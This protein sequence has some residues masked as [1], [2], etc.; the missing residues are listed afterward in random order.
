MTTTRTINGINFTVNP[1]I[2]P[3]KNWKTDIYDLYDHPSCT[4]VRIFNDWDKKI[5]IYWLTGNSSVFSIYWSI[6][7][8]EGKDHNV[9]ITPSYNYLID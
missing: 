1:K 9:K 4:K 6:R 5:C 3:V 8:D 7:D 2:T